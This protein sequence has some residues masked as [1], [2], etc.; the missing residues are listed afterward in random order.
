VT[1]PIY[2]DHHAT[3]PCDP[4]V[5]EAMLP[6]FTEHFGNAASGSHGHGRRA[7][8][9]V[10]LARKQVAELIGARS[11]EIVFTSGA[12]ESNNLAL[13]GVV[14]ATRSGPHHLITSITEHRAVLDTAR[15]LEAQGHDVTWLQPSSD[16][17]LS[18][19]KVEAAIKPQTVLVSVMH[20]NNEI[21]A[22]NELAAIG[23]VCMDAG[24]LFHTDAAQSASVLPIDVEEMGLDLLSLSGHK[25]YGPKGIGALYVRSRHPKVS[26]APQMHGGGHERGVRSGTLPVPLVVGFGEACCIAEVERDDVA[27]HALNLRQRML[28][29]LSDELEGMTVHGSIDHRLPGNLNVSFDGVP[30]DALMADLP[31]VSVSSGS[32]CS[33]GTIEPSYVLRAIGVDEDSAFE[34]IRFG[35]GRFNT[36]EEIDTAAR[37]VIAS[38]RRLRSLRKM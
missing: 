22:V 18:P 3:T 35:I 32:A 21:G 7:A 13:K 23:R 34:S 16:G 6:F 28:D 36:V 8:A 19:A 38:V 20:A 2:L 9:A 11:R 29:R 30:S 17:R 37:Q 1:A 26:L 25:M 27:S 10:E 24:V 14:E 5:V 31:G 12:T 4:R 33:S 15:W